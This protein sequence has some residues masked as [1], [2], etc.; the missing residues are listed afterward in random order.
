MKSQEGNSQIYLP[1]ILKIEKNTTQEFWGEDKT[2]PNPID[3]KK[4]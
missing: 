4:L 3:R 1:N 2:N